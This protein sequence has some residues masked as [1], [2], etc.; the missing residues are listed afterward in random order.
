MLPARNEYDHAKFLDRHMLVLTED[1][2]QRTE[3]E[4]RALY[5]AGGFEL[6]G[7]MIPTSSALSITE[8]SPRE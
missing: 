1:G 4:F 6:I 5:E 3:S 2:R 7:V 8:G